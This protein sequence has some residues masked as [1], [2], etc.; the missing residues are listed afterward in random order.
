MVGGCALA[1]IL[2]AGAVCGQSG[3]GASRQVP[4]T[5]DELTVTARGPGLRGRMHGV[6]PGQSVFVFTW[7]RPGNFFENHNLSLVPVSPAIREALASLDRHQEA[8]VRGVLKQGYGSQPHLMVEAVEPGEKW[9][10]GVPV[11]VRRDPPRDLARNLAGKSR[12]TALVHALALDGGMLVVEWRTFVIP[13]QVPETLRAGVAALFRGDRIRFR[14]RVASQPR[15]PVHLTLDPDLTGDRRALEVLDSIH[16]QHD[17]ERTVTGRLVLFPRSPVL[18]RSIWAVED[19]G[20]DGL[21][22]YFTI[23]NFSDAKDQDRTDAL[24]QEAWTAHPEGVSDGRN[25]YIH[26]RVRVRVRGAVSNPAPNQANPT[27]VTT[28]EQVEI[29]TGKPAG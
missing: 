21:H 3:A 1:V 6:A 28:S 27:L 5:L 15:E 17:Q 8:V 18:R 19:R 24:L 23:F 4:L 20:D 2:S 16:E 26:T 11:A 9:A 13:V 22:R 14:F 12:L 25:K 29:V 10:P 7:T